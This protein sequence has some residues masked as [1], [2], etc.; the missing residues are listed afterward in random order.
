[1]QIRIT[2]NSRSPDTIWH[3]LAARLGREPTEEEA[4]VEVRRILA[5]GTAERKGA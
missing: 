2:W 5:E 1:M 3:R 4:R